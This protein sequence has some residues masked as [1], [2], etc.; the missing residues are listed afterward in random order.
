MKSLP[1]VALAA[2]SEDVQLAYDY[3]ESQLPD[4]GERFVRNFFEVMER[5][6]SNAWL[7][8][9]KFD[10]YHLALISKSNYAAYYFILDDRA[11]IGAGMDA[12]RDP[13]LTRDLIRSRKDDLA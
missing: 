3:F 8:P 4:A 9:L 1:V 7:Y 13:R 12:R 6:A 11:G 5:I 10:D 2:A